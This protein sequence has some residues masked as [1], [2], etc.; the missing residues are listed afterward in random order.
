[1]SRWLD[2]D[3]RVDVLNDV[4][5]NQVL[6][7]FRAADGDHDE[8]IRRVVRAV[9]DEGTCWMSGTTWRG[10]AAIWRVIHRKIRSRVHLTAKPGYVLSR[11]AD[12]G[13]RGVGA[14]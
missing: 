2:R 4:V 3:P 11:Y 10:R 13:G 9:Q 14:A 5:L 12:G 6:V 8:L 7:L 1:M